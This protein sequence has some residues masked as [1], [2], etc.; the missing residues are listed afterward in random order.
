[1]K[2]QYFGV[3]TRL[4]Q[5]RPVSPHSPIICPLLCLL[6]SLSPSF[7]PSSVLADNPTGEAPTA[8]FSYVVEADG[9]TKNV[10]HHVWLL[11]G[12][13]FLLTT[14]TGSALVFKPQDMTAKA[15]AYEKPDCKLD[16]AVE[17]K[18]LF[19][20]ANV[21]ALWTTPGAAGQQQTGQSTK[22][23]KFQNP[24]AEQLPS[25]LTE[26]CLLVS[27]PSGSSNGEKGRVR[28]QGAQPETPTVTL[29]FHSSAFCPG[30]GLSL[31]A[32]LSGVLSFF[33]FSP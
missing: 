4:P 19:P 9:I 26:F 10:T 3:P 16:K 22:F 20:S 6:L 13:S 30:V 18:N 33:L 5:H 23:Y 14:K 2:A 11:G 25:S 12:Q 29:V 17:Y 1:M 15:Y 8:D 32:S 24:P 31:V 27:G 7:L 28:G 21:D